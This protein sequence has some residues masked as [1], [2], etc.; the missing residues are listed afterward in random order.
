MSFCPKCGQEAAPAAAF[1]HACGCDLKQA[2]PRAGERKPRPPQRQ[3]HRGDRKDGHIRPPHGPNQA[4]IAA[5]AALDAKHA[6]KRLKWMIVAVAGIVLAIGS[7]MAYSAY[8]NDFV[9]ILIFIGVVLLIVG[10]IAM[11]GERIS[12]EQYQSLP[13]ALTEQGHRCIF[14]GGRGIYRHT[15]YKTNKTLADCSHCKAE[16]WEE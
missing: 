7:S 16:L 5:H 6:G 8:Q 15:P 3:Q 1:C 4:G 14:C 10:S 11:P 2:I 9:G 13:G 12:E